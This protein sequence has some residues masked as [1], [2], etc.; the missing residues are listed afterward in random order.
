LSDVVPAGPSKGAVIT[1][2]VLS[3]V[4]ALMLLS[5]AFTAFS[6]APMVKE[7]M[8]PLGMPVTLLPVVATIELVCSVLYLV[9]RT[10]VIGALLM[11]AYMGGAVLAHLRVGQPT[12]PVPVVFGILVWAGLWL[13]RPGLRR[14]MLGV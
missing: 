14:D 10:A 11:T 6:G 8:A 1:G 12:W 13:R 2:W 4:P 3:L 7:G 9:P 5:G